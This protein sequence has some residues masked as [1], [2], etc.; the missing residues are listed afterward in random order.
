MAYERAIRELLELSHRVRPVTL[1]SER[2]IPVAGMLGEILPGG[3][4]RRGS[5]VAVEGPGATS[6][7]VDLLA[8]TTRAGEWAALVDDLTVSVPA[9]VEAEIGR[10]VV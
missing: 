10:A 3:G 6:V 5:V 2:V 7:L 9:L 8:A 4:L 1:A